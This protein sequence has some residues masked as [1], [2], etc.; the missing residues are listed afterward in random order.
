[1][2]WGRIRS[3]RTFDQEGKISLQFG[4]LENIDELINTTDA[5]RTS[6][7]RY[8]LIAEN[9]T[10]MITLLDDRLRFVYVSPNVTEITGFARDQLLHKPIFEFFEAKDVPNLLSFLEGLNPNNTGRKNSI[11]IRFK[12]KDESIKW[13]ETRGVQIA[14]SSDEEAAPLIQLISSDVTEKRKAEKAL[15]ESEKRF[16]TI[17]N[18]ANS[19]I[20]YIDRDGQIIDLNAPI[21]ERLN[22]SEANLLNQLFWDNFL[23]NF[24]DENM[25]LAK[26]MFDKAVKGEFLNYIGQIR[27]GRNDKP[28][29][30]IAMSPVMDDQSQRIEYIVAEIRDITE[31]VTALQELEKNKQFIDQ[32]IAN[33]PQTVLVINILDSRVI[34]NNIQDG[35]LG[36]TLKEWQELESSL[37]LSIV[38]QDDA[39]HLEEHLYEQYRKLEQNEVYERQ[40]RAYTKSGDIRYFAATFFVFDQLMDNSNE[41]MMMVATDITER[42]LSEEKVQIQMDELNEKN[43]ELEKYIDSNLELE[44]FAYITSHDL[45]EPLRNIRVFTQLLEKQYQGKF[46]EKGVE[47]MDFIKSSAAHMNQLIEDILEFSRINTEDIRY[48]QIKLESLFARVENN[49]NGKIQDAQAQIDYQN[50]PEVIYGHPTRLYQLFYNLIGNAIKFKQPDLAPKI[51]IRS[52][53]N[54]THWTFQIQDNGIGFEANYSE[55]VFLLFKRL[56]SRTEYQGSGIGL[57]ICR[58]VVQQHH[59]KIWVDSTPGKGSTF[60]FSIAKASPE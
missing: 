15:Q 33:F 23:C 53:E 59:G 57:A 1:R 44:N 37:M 8:R 34:Y 28:I 2:F 20:A 6:E 45:K 10:D 54:A 52:E 14:E 24:S 26:M 47:Y 31:K 39:A 22:V 56:H 12:R 58:K 36:Y 46:D 49:L 5:L 16:R 51:Q 3:T 43:V 29:V 11:T 50:L 13:L 27:F 9:T 30:E 48:E 7:N 42:V 18:H 38:H 21:R 55:K 4:V 25:D 32:V 60:S 19:Y 35:F 40:I 41:N 17:F